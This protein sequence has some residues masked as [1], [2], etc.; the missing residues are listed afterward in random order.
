MGQR[1]S[2]NLLLK[3][4]HTY[5]AVFEALAISPPCSVDGKWYLTVI[6]Y[7]LDWPSLHHIGRWVSAL[8]LGV[9]VSKYT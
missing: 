6:L 7:H 2:I 5:I 1:M 4:E 8:G 9:Q 3:S